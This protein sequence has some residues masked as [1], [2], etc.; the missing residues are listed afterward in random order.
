M[1]IQGMDPNAAF[2]V[3]FGAT[4]APVQNYYDY[5][6]MVFNKSGR[7]REL[8]RSLKG[9]AS[10]AISLLTTGNKD[11]MIRGTK[12]WEEIN[13]TIWSSNLSNSLKLELQRSLIRVEI[14]P[15]IMRNAMRLGLEYDAELLTQQT[16]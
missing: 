16:R 10:Q 8:S 5:Q 3:L 12:L 2:A 11:D 9:D 14:L 1:V 4:P 13:D 6:E 7:Y 15:E